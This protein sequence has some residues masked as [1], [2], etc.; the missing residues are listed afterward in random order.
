MTPD[1]KER[2]KQLDAANKKRRDRAIKNL[3][4]DVEL[5]RKIRGWSDSHI[6]DV[7]GITMPKKTPELKPRSA[8]TQSKYRRLAEQNAKAFSQRNVFD[9]RPVYLPKIPTQ[10]SKKVKP[11]AQPKIDKKKKPVYK[12]PVV[13][14]DIIPTEKVDDEPNAFKS[15]VK[16][17]QS[18]KKLWAKWSKK[19]Q[20]NMPKAIKAK[21]YR[22][23]R[24]LNLDENARYGF[25]IVYKSF[26][27]K[28]AINVWKTRYAP[29][30][31]YEG[32]LYAEV[33]KIR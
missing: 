13:V 12:V 4:G 33:Y 3:T 11:S 17:G 1:A 20:K 2:K 22:I 18:R 9:E 26:M 28:E 31:A 25:F 16:R 30:F 21:A 27:T 10:V 7:Y 29:D 24:E 19:N 14:E 15:L 32:D 6:K 23:N 8:K 5:A